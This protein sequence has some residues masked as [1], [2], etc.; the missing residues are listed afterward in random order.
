[1][2]NMLVGAN[3]L[4]AYIAFYLSNCVLSGSPNKKRTGN[5]GLICFCFV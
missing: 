3:M 2:L 1:M 5:N 4:L